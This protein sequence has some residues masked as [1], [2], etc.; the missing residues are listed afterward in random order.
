MI[1]S[2]RMVSQTIDGLWV[3]WA[4]YWFV[5][6]FG[7]KRTVYRQRFGS[8][9]VHRLLLIGAIVVLLNLDD[10]HVRLFRETVWTQVGGIILCA[11]G[12]AVSIWARRVLG[13]NWSGV[14]TLKENHELIRRGPYRLVRHP[15]YSGIILALIGTVLAAAP[16]VW[17]AVVVV[18]LA[19]SFKL[20]SLREEKLMLGQFPGDYE[21]Y[22]KDV[23]SLIPHVI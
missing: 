19:I 20:R 10:S 9:V 2:E 22:M 8:L 12:V 7:N 3:I 14:V 1:L 23:K 5:N 15:I 6:A 11:A 16:Y 4:A 17:G 18:I 21:Q 13:G